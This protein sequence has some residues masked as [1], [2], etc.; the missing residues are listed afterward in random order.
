LVVY[1]T[2]LGVFRLSIFEEALR[3]TIVMKQNLR[4]Q[5]S[6]IT[7]EDKIQAL[8]IIEGDG[9]ITMPVSSSEDK[10]STS[11]FNKQIEEQSKLILTKEVLAS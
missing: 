5:L 7:D 4:A 6:K 9:Q 11:E 1:Q 3:D 8:R 10:I 2:D